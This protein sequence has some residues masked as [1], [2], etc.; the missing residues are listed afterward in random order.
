MDVSKIIERVAAVQNQDMPVVKPDWIEEE[1]SGQRV[2]M[3]SDK[4][5]GASVKT[6]AVLEKEFQVHGSVV[7]FRRVAAVRMPKGMAHGAFLQ[8]LEGLASPVQNEM[9]KIVAGLRQ[10]TGMMSEIDVPLMVGEVNDG[11]LRVWTEAKADN[12]S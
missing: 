10:T 2:L 1:K 11:W 9:S 8:M 4:T 5:A 12:A 3:D 7:R 6:A